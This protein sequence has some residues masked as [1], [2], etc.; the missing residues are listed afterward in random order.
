MKCNMGKGE[1]IFRIIAGIVIIAVGYYYQSW[2]GTVGLI[3]LLTGFVSFCPAYMPFKFTTAK[4][5]EE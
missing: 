1:R 3:P 2:W 5:K 4:K